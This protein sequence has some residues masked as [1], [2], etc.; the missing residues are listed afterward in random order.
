MVGHQQLGPVGD[1]ELGGGHA[2]ADNALQLVYQLGH[3]QRHAVSDHIG[4][5]GIEDARG[6]DMQCEA[7]KIIDNGMPRIGPALKADDHIGLLGQH[8]GDFALALIAPVGAY[9]CFYHSCYLRG[10]GFATGRVCLIRPYVTAV[11]YCFFPGGARGKWLKTSQ[12][13]VRSWDLLR[14]NVP[15]SG[16]GFLCKN[17]KN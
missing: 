1:D 12:N 15:V 9:D 2:L 14:L 7:A 16:R 6:E 13:R 10:P 17:Q 4:H 11:L 3:I 5:M 8:I